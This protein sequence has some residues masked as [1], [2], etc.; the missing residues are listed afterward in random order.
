METASRIQRH[1]VML[2]AGLFLP[3]LLALALPASAQG[4]WSAPATIS[5]AGQDVTPPQIAVNQNGDAVFV[6]NAK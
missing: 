5:P 6:W 3:L 2:L 1:R 4:V